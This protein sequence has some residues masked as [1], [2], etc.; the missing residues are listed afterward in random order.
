M[1]I[2]LDYRINNQ[3]IYAMINL[4]PSGYVLGSKV[5]HFK[6]LFS[7]QLGH[8]CYQFN[9]SDYFSILRT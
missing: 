3:R 7:N 5:A 8:R 1:Y 6:I 2:I 4:F 9:Y